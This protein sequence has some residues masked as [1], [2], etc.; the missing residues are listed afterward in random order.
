[1]K[2]PKNFQEKI[3]FFV[4]NQLEYFVGSTAISLEIL[5]MTTQSN[6]PY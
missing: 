5:R 3:F 4:K 1:M 2:L 6:K